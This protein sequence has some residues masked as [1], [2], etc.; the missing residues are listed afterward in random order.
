MTV[1]VQWTKVSNQPPQILLH[2]FKLLIAI[3]MAKW[4]WKNLKIS[5]SDTST[6]PIALD[7]KC[8]S[9]IQNQLPYFTS[10]NLNLAQFESFHGSDLS[11]KQIWLVFSF[12]LFGWLTPPFYG[13]E[14]A[15]WHNKYCCGIDSSQF[16][17]TTYLTFA[18]FSKYFSSCQGF[19]LCQRWLIV[20]REIG[21]KKSQIK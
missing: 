7:Y 21:T 8:N 10:L 20:V 16:F 3:E 9:S 15:F 14:K 2:M 18:A 12:E 5:L 17:A 4:L 11:F 6:T 19:S 1:T 13:R